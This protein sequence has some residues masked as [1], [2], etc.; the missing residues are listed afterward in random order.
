MHFLDQ[1]LNYIDT[2][3]VLPLFE[4][5]EV[6]YKIS[7]L[8]TTDWNT[9]SALVVAV[10]RD[11]DLAQM[12]L[13][14]SIGDLRTIFN[15]LNT[16]DE[17]VFLRNTFGQILA[18]EASSASSLDPKLVA[19]S[20]LNYLPEAIY[21]IPT[22]LQSQTWKRHKPEL[23]ETLIY[24]APT[25]LRQ[26]VLLENEL[27]SFIRHPFALLLQEL[28]RVSLQD[29][30]ALVELIAL[31]LRSAEA[32]LDL[33][34]GNL[35]PETPRLLVG[36][37]TAIR[38][39]ASSLF[40]IALD[41]I[42]EASNH[43]KAEKESLRLSIKD[44][45]DGFTIVRSILRVD[46]LIC[47]VLKIGDH[48][49]LT[50]SDPP[51]NAPFTRPFS[52]DALVLTTEMGLATFRCLHRPPS[53]IE[54]CAWT[55]TQCGSFVTSKTLFDA[56]TSFYSQREACCKIYGLLLGLPD[57]DQI[58]LPSVELPVADV[59]SLNKSQN[60]ALAASM[61]HPL[62]F[63][64]G[65]PGT[66][67]TYTIVVILMQLLKALPKSRF[68]VTAPTHNAVDNL[69]RRFIH[70]AEAKKCGAVPVRVST[71]VSTYLKP[72]LSLLQQS[73]TDIISARKGRS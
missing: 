64:W 14:D 21:L 35:E 32:T 13:L 12:R 42:D 3:Q 7:K 36:R 47:R 17:R 70:D 20:L 24:L 49:Q 30:A 9:Y 61:K 56:V 51:Q 57:A 67:K 58:K 60:A 40:G 38:R 39:F 72:I 28:K 50:V 54:E 52:I 2:E 5:L 6:S 16:H 53:Y 22:F 62:T 33:L 55:I 41:H 69:L 71:Q 73:D 26:L 8:E 34:L 66:G 65:P 10:V 11:K 46:S 18:L 68:L 23:E 27:G 48:V 45:K 29:F 25:L 4:K 43:R 44:Y 63:I 1:W 19:S 31:S 59:S 37:P 15:L